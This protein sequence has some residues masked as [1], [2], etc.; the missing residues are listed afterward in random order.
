M[1]GQ[2]QHKRDPASPVY[3]QAEILPKDESYPLSQ[4][5]SRLGS[6]VG[7]FVGEH[8]LFISIIVGELTGNAGVGGE[9][10]PGALCSISLPPLS[11]ENLGS[12]ACPA[13][14]STPLLGAPV[15]LKRSHL[16][17]IDVVPGTVRPSCYQNQ[18]SHACY[19]HFSEEEIKPQRSE[20]VSS[21]AED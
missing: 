11:L 5:V 16:L 15:S 12:P 18:Q 7:A 8:G 19:P 2:T 10:L 20:V 6:W 3:P 21:P 14:Q 13:C 17:C 1:G 4:A 9:C